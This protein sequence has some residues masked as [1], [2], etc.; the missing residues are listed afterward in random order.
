M[1]RDKPVRVRGRQQQYTLG[2]K[3]KAIKEYDR[4]STLGGSFYSVAKQ[5]GIQT[6]QMS[7]WYKNKTKIME[8]AKLDPSRLTVNE[9]RKVAMPDVEEVIKSYYED[10]RSHNCAVS[11]ELLVDV[12]AQNK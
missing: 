10:L 6:G 7:R 1:V 12:R 11:T 3:I 2:F 4:T 8:R 9:G 5:F